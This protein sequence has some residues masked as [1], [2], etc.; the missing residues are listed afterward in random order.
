MDKASKI[1]SLFFNTVDDKPFT[2][3]SK[4]DASLLEE[5]LA[6]MVEKVFIP[7]DV[8]FEFA[9]CE[10]CIIKAQANMSKESME[11]IQNFNESELFGKMQLINDFIDE[12]I[13]YIK[14]Q[15]NEEQPEQDFS[16]CSIIGHFKGNKMHPAMP[17]ICVSEA[18]INEV[19]ELFSKKTRD[20]MDDFMDF[21]NNVPPGFEKLFDKPK[22][23]LI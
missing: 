2:N 22:P 7:N 4:C 1:P 20:D 3:C 14:N 5:N 9:L 23:I 19:Q 12:D 18:T 8:L 11:R 16:R 6:Y 10:H 15:L 13:D 17:V 21:I